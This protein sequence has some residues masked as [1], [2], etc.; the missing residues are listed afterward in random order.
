MDVLLPG[1]RESC[2]PKWI[3]STYI[4]SSLF[5]CFRVKALRKDVTAKCVCV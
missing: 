3:A 4:P 1:K 5:F 2:T